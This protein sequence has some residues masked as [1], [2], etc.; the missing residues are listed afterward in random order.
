[1]KTYTLYMI[2]S[3]LLEESGDKPERFSMAGLR[4]VVKGDKRT[5]MRRFRALRAMFAKS[6]ELDLDE[7][8]YP[9]CMEVRFLDTDQ[10]GPEDKVCFWVEAE[11]PEL[12][13]KK[14]LAFVNNFGDD[15]VRG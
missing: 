10:R 15:S 1:M 8:T 6:P 11:L 4:A 3:G 7:F 9:D 13:N 2:H 12:S 5:V 14:V